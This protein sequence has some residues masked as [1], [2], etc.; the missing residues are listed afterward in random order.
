MLKQKISMMEALLDIQIA[1]SMLKGPSVGESAIDA[2][3]KKLNTDLTP[4][5]V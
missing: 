5:E 4:L 1:T 2:S 3:Y